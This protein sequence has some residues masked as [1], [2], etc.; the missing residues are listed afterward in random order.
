M[1]VW[2]AIP[3]ARPLHQVEPI[4]RKWLDMGYKV[5]LWRDKPQDGDYSEIQW[6]HD[7]KVTATWKAAYPGYAQAVNSMCRNILGVDPAADWIVTGGDDVEPDPNRRAH[8]IARECSDHFGDTWAERAS[9]QTF[10]TFDEVR[11]ARSFGVMQP[12]GDTWSDF[13]EGKKSR[14]IERIAGSPWMGR[15]FCRRMYQGSGPL[16][17]EFFHCFEDEHLQAVAQ[18]LGV[19]WQRPD[20]THYHHHFQ[21]RGDGSAHRV[22]PQPPAHLAKATSK[23]HWEES[24]AIFER[25]KA[26][27]FAEANDLLP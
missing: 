12:T 6:A 9:P 17:P 5:M 11:K 13:H 10:A 23:E 26:G 20:L 3:S 16:W 15:E 7:M 19:F 24:K 4:I 27:G 2:L 8:E 25:L 1:S 14:I 21:R 22:D 18:K